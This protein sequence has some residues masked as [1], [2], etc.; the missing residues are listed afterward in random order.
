MTVIRIA[1]MF[2]LCCIALPA[3]AQSEEPASAPWPRELTDGD[4]TVTL[5]QPQ[6][7]EWKDFE[8]LTARMAAVV[9]VEPEAAPRIGALFLRIQTFTELET[10]TVSVVG[11]DSLGIHFPSVA[12]QAALQAGLERI[13][14]E[15]I[16]ASATWSLDDVLASLDAATSA[17]MEY[18][19]QME[20]PPIYYSESPAV[21]VIFD[22]EPFFAPVSPRSRKVLRSSS[23]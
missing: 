3:F 12:D 17:R 7:E 11:L 19:L 4:A 1:W 5:H 22:G 9:Q 20:P 2:A 18:E 8:F 16:R 13:V 6:V 10:R 15:A 14:G 21:L 23:R